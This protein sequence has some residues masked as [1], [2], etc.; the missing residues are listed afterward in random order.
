[1]QILVTNDDGYFAPG[2]E[3]LIRLA[4][5]F[6]DVTLVAPETEQS[7]MGHRVTASTQ[8]LIATPYA[9]HSFHVNGTPA[10][11]VR[12]A[13][14]VLQLK[15][16]FVLSGINKGGNLGVDIYTSGTVAAAR[17][18][19]IWGIPAIAVSQ[20][21]KR[22]LPLDWQHSELLAATA[23]ETILAQAPHPGLYWNVNLPHLPSPEAPIAL[24]A[25]DPSPQDVHYTP[26]GAG[27]RY[28]GT[29][30]K[31]PA[32]PGHDVANCFAGRIAISRLQL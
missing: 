9:D 32:K 14:H 12:I 7:Y 27:H 5:R 25:P 31:R 2:I 15:P 13:L 18:A 6:G 16:D 10:D 24:C 17:E 20:Y 23:I 8:D 22:D 30:A 29:Y 1:M 26:N 28:S 11:C 19:A 4:S 3:T 21:V